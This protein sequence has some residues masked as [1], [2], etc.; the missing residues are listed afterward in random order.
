MET[1]LMARLIKKWLREKWQQDWMTGNPGAL[2]N[3]KCFQKATENKGG[4][5]ITESDKGEEQVW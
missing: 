2:K 1:L 5:E 4:R 3:G